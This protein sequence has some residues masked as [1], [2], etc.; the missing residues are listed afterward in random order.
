MRTFA[1]Q[2]VGGAVVG[3]IRADDDA[4]PPAM[5]GGP[6]HVVTLIDVDDEAIETS[7]ADAESRMLKAFEEIQA[8]QGSA[9]SS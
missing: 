5:S 8:S 4:P 1:V 2:T 9:G 3:I 6:G 7:G